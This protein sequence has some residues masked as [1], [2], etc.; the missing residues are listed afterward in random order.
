MVDD[1][2]A[3]VMASVSHDPSVGLVLMIA[4]GGLE[5][6]LWNDSTLLA[7]PVT[8]AELERALDRLKV[9]QRI[10]GWRSRPAGDRTAL[11]D[12]LLA[13]VGFVERQGGT[14]QEIEINPLLVGRRGV[15]AVD[16]V[17]KMERTDAAVA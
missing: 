17:L 6:E 16:A 9:A 1:V 8:C 7:F 5:A 15:L 10:A 4:G 12:A 11:V 14:V 2:V 3:E 13:L